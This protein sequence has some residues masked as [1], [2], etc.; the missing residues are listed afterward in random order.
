M[1]FTVGGATTNDECT[2]KTD[3]NP[4]SSVPSRIFLTQVAL[5]TLHAVTTE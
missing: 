2:I 3:V 5:K 1:L 4:Q